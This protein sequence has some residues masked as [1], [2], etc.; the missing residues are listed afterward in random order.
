MLLRLRNLGVWLARRVGMTI[1]DER[2]GQRIGR[3]LVVPWRGKIHVVGLDMPMRVFWLPQKRITYWK[4]E[5][6]FATHPPP[7][8]PNERQRHTNEPR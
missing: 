5:I 6:G 1:T 4:Q 3:A 2:T 7:D 8:F